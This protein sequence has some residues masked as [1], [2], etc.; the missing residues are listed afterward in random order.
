MSGSENVQPPKLV[1]GK[2]QPIVVYNI[3]QCS[4]FTY[5]WAKNALKFEIFHSA[6]DK[7]SRISHGFRRDTCCLWTVCCAQPIHGHGV[8]LI[9]TWRNDLTLLKYSLLI[10]AFV[11]CHRAWKIRIVIEREKKLKTFSTIRRTFPHLVGFVSGKP[12]S[13]R[14]HANAEVRRAVPPRV[15]ALR[16]TRG[17]LAVKKL[18]QKRSTLYVSHDSAVTQGNVVSATA[19]SYGNA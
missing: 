15:F 2:K 17:S 8:L 14:L 3:L 5:L 16:R 12:V 10:N 1:T 19:A 13:P 18:K 9:Y 11:N 4:A 7:A 6:Q